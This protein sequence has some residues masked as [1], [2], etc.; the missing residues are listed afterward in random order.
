MKDQSMPITDV[1][2]WRRRGF[3]LHACWQFNYPFSVLSWSA[4]DYVGMFRLLRLLDIDTVMLWPMMESIPAPLS[5]S[6]AAELESARSVVDTARATGLECW[7]VQ[8]ANVTS[9]LAIAEKSLAHRHLYPNKQIVRLDNVRERT[10]FLA[11]RKAMLSIVNNAD[12]Y[13]TIDGDPGGYPD[14]DPQEFVDIIKHDRG[15]IDEIGTHP[16]AQKVIPWLW[17]GWGDH[18]ETVGP[19]NEPIEPLTQPVITR[20]KEQMRE[21]WA[22]LPGRSNTDRWANGRVNIALAEQNELIDRSMLLLYEIVEFEPCAPACVIQFDSIRRVMRQ[23]GR[24]AKD[25]LGCMVNAQQPIMALPNLWFFARS[26]TDPTYLER[27][28]DDVLADFAHFLGGNAR[29]LTSA[30]R[31]L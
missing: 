2:P 25:A 15:L 19:W 12:G 29:L 24:L 4:D 18:W 20:L 30:W 27:D 8:T 28:T 16:N 22:L 1:R 13:V 10:T 6:D 3:Y 23:E 21:P 5:R 17:C 31:S 14:A 11:H 26:A 9:T 7:I